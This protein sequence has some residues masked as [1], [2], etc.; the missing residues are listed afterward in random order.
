MGFSLQAPAWLLLSCGG[1]SKDVRLTDLGVPDICYTI[2]YGW[3]W[4]P[5]RS[6]PFKGKRE[7]ACSALAGVFPF[8]GPK[9][10]QGVRL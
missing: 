4:N 2:T 10:E 3:M 6:H 7:D 9:S 8:L 5:S 1:R